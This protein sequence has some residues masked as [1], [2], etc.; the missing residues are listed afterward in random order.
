MDNLDSEGVLKFQDTE[1]RLKCVTIKTML[2]V[3]LPLTMFVTLF[4][5]LLLGYPVA[6]TIGGIATLFGGLGAFLGVFD[7]IFFQIFP[8]RIFGLVSNLTLIAIPLFIFMGMVLAK[9]GLAERLL[10][11]MGALFGKVP[12]GL[13]VSVILV[14][15]LLAASTGIVSATVITMTLISLPVMLK[16]HYSA[17]AATGT[18]AAAGTLGQIVPPSIV[19]ILLADV[20]SNPATSVGKVFAAAIVPSLLLIGSYLIFSLL[21]SYY[22][23]IPPV[24]TTIPLSLRSLLTTLLPPLVLISCVLGSILTGLATPTE[25]AAVGATGAI[26]LAFF[27]ARKKITTT[28]WD[29]AEETVKITAMILLILIA[30]SA[31][32]L[33]FRGM[34]GDVLIQDFL[35]NLALSPY[36]VL[37]IVMLLIFLVGFFL[38]FIEIIYI[39][40]PI[41]APILITDFGFDPLLIVIL[42]ALN[43][44]TSFLTPPLG[45]TLF[46]LKGAAPKN[47]RMQQIIQGVVPFIFIQICV[48][49]LVLI[50]PELVTTLPEFLANR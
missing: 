14:G 20:L 39:F 8:S 10:E 1:E 41:L 19:L 45:F 26:V 48:I 50:W 31:F 5:V 22:Q 17:S 18:I 35:I 47:I 21:K 6:L 11:I 33:I 16:Q 38:D 43:L 7:P 15:G 37:A 44:Q 30:A 3:L 42:F 9:S 25:S 40:V 34:G 13:A 4:F 23:K 49:A 2:E 46:C 12:G 32:S 28:I 36:L 24:Q 29:S 27:F